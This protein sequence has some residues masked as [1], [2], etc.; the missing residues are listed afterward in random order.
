MIRFY[1]CVA[2]AAISAT[3]VGLMFGPTIGILSGVPI[4]F[5]FAHISG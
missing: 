4:G 5:F 1:A 3:L 2:G